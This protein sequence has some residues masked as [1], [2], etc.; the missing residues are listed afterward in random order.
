MKTGHLKTGRLVTPQLEVY[1][2]MYHAGESPDDCPGKEFVDKVK[3]FKRVLHPAR[4]PMRA[5]GQRCVRAV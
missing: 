3:V 1:M 2:C 5:G 4:W